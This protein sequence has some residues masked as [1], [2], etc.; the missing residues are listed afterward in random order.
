[1]DKTN[2]KV[3]R[4]IQQFHPF[5]Y[6]KIIQ[7]HELPHIFNTIKQFYINVGEKC[8][9]VP[10]KSVTPI[11]KKLQVNLSEYTLIL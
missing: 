1:M 10:P 6:I 8:K 9:Y 7:T 2:F 5:G 11:R 4:V 3:E